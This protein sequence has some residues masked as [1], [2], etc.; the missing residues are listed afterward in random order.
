MADE[1]GIAQSG[2]DPDMLGATAPR[3]TIRGGVRTL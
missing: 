3:L 2:Q 1:P